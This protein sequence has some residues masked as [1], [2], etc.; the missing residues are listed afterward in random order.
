MSAF[1]CAAFKRARSDS[2]KAFHRARLKAA[3]K[4]ALTDPN[5]RAAQER[6]KQAR[7]EFREAMRPALIKADPGV[8]PILEKMKAEKAKDE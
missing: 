3:H 6:L 8:Q 1:L 7:R 2:D 4:N 5:V